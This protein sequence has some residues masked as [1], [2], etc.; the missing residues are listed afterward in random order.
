MESTTET[1]NWTTAWGTELYLAG[2]ENCDT[3]YLLPQQQKIMSCPHC[4]V[5]EL[6]LMDEADDKP[7][8]T[9]PPE[10]LV[11][12][13]VPPE[14]INKDLHAFTRSVWMKPEDMKMKRLHGRLQQIY[15][16]LWLVD[17][18]VQAR[19][20][21]EVGYD[22]EVVSHR[23]IY[24]NDKW[25]TQRFRETKIRWEPRV[26]TLTR[27]YD[28]HIGPALEEHETYAQKLGRF[29]LESAESYQRNSVMQ[30]LVRLPNRSPE[31]S[32]STVM[33]EFR[34]T[35]IK[36]CE[37]ATTADHIRE[38]KW[39]A[40]FANKNW[41]QMLLPIYTTYYLDDD[42]KAQMIFIHGQTGNI[43]GSKR[44]SMKK[45]KKYTMIIFAVAAA[46]GILSFLLFLGGM[47]LAEGLLAL[48][49]LGFFT[50]VFIGIASLIPL[51]IALYT[52]HISYINT[53]QQLAKDIATLSQ[54]QESV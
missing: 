23:E 54:S 26:G 40:N 53:A 28:N 1:T 52:N 24:K 7:I 30:A 46:I 39:K 9:H 49:S 29:R 10:Q 11:P 18:D 47:F 3:N 25:V 13:A 15:L 35:A 22:Y 19:W 12:F 48:A 33:H 21:A 45:A 32:W 31:D 17:A 4:G 34:A 50:A 27:H 5:G 8:Y 42:K 2:C 51:A 43:Y 41:T 20:Q 16:P 6:L 14:K 36:E 37:Q 44:A 38:F